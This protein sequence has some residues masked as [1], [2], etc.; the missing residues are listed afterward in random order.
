M[1]LRNMRVRWLRHRKRK[2]E[3][4][5][6]RLSAQTIGRGNGRNA[7]NSAAYRAAEKL[8]DERLGKTFSYARKQGVEHTEILAPEGAPAWVCDREKLWNVVEAAEKRKDAQVA[9]EVQVSLPVELTSARQLALVRE[10][11]QSQFVARG[12]VADVTIHKDDPNNPHAHIM[13]TTRHLADDSF[14]KKLMPASKWHERKSELREWRE[15]WCDCQNRALGQAGHAVRVD[16]RSYKDRGIQLEPQTKIG[17]SRGRAADDGRELVLERMAEHDR[18]A[19]ENGERIRQDPAIALQAIT[20][21][22]ATFTRQ[23]VGRWLNTHTADAEQ[24]QACLDAVMASAE[25]VERGK[26]AYGNARYTTNEMLKVERRMVTNAEEMAERSG[27]KVA[28][29][30]I[31]QAEA[32][33]S[34]SD[35]QRAAMRHVVAATGDIAVAEGYAG[36]GKSYM[37]GAAREAWEAEGYRVHGAALAGKAAEGLELSSGISS[38]SIHSFEF[39]WKHGRDQL[40]SRHVLVIDEAGM[41]GSRQ[42]DRVLER[43]RQAGAKVVLVGDTEQL[44][45]IEAGAPMRAIA[46]RVGQVSLG[47][48]R[49]QEVAWQRRASRDFAEGRTTKALDAYELGGNIHEHESQASAMESMVVGPATT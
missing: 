45:A 38:R 10:F 7:V 29:R 47:E 30:C 14:G 28:E 33:R 43:A 24:F 2:P 9:R 26:D 31:K 20:H 27:H 42:L 48:I 32:S 16:H 46:E 34:L 12:M 41:V 37:L 18:I 8:H 15:A 40:T 21:Q 17:A 39:A 22:R 6:Y 23:D 5:V 3:M 1:F 35:E 13:L 25:L 44:Q 4:A 11:A 19:R 49:R 36:A